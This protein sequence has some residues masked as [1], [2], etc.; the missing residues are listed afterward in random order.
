MHYVIFC[1]AS[2]CGTLIPASSFE[3]TLWN[4]LLRENKPQ[5]RCEHLPDFQSMYTQL[6]WAYS[7][8]QHPASVC[9]CH[10]C[11]VVCCWAGEWG[12]GAGSVLW[13]LFP[14]EHGQ[15]SGLS[16]VWGAAAGF[17][18]QHCTGS[19]C[20]GWASGYTGFTAALNLCSMSSL[21]AWGKMFEITDV[22]N[23]AHICRQAC[24]VPYQHIVRC[25]SSRWHLCN[26][27]F[28][29]V[30]PIQCQCFNVL[31]ELFIT[32]FKT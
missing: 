20:I 15:S 25:L 23:K 8:F 27:W 19:R 14:A 1:T 6:T 16:A 30:I 2:T 7:L 11:F 18:L 22:V 26:S 4:P 9:W 13:R 3:E 12:S 24:E 31:C 17:W 28:V 10:L 5:Q 21:S 29:P 32:V